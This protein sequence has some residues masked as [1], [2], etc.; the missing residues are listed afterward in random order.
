MCF[1]AHAT[2]DLPP[3]EGLLSTFKFCIGALLKVVEECRGSMSKRCAHR[4]CQRGPS[5]TWLGQYQVLFAICQAL[6]GP[7]STKM[8]FCMALIHAGFV[9]ATI[10]FLV[11]R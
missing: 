4:P 11:W 3:S 8:L 6:P 1:G 7:G 10:V 9:A 2:L 5:L